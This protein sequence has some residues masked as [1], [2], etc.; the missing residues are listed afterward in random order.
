MKDKAMDIQA[1]LAALADGN[2]SADRSAE[3]ARLAQESPELTAQLAEQRRV[4]TLLSSIDTSAPPALHNAIQGFTVSRPARRPVV[5][6]RW[7]LVGVAALACAAV[8]AVTLALTTGTSGL[9]T[10]SQ[11]SKLALR[12]AAVG[13]P[14]ESPSNQALLASSVDGIAYPYWGK[15]FGWETDGARTDRLGGRTITTVFY[16]NAHA[17]R[18]GYS[19]V[20]GDALTVPAGHSVTQGGV[21]FRVLDVSGTTVVTWRRAGH[22]CILTARSVSSTTLLRLAGWQRS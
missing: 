9:P 6:T 7:S 10:V 14:A 11:A 18:I 1:E 2:L 3:V 5:A 12:P 20:A 13:S 22:T 16:R 8:L 19:I 15:R 21:S 17:Q 4:S